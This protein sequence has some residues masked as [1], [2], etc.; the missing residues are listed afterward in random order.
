MPISVLL[1]DGDSD[2]AQSVVHALVDPWL[3]WTV[4]MA[5]TL[6]QARR[7]LAR[8]QIDVVLTVRSMA[9]G[10]A[11]DV[12]KM[13]DDVPALIMVLPGEEAQAAQ[14]MRHGFS[15]FLVQT[16]QRDHLLALPAQIEAVL[17]RSTVARARQTAEAM[18]ARQHRLLQAIS[19]VQ[20]IFI[21]QTSPRAAFD[22][23]LQEL[24]ALTGSAFGLVGQVQRAPQGLPFLRVHAMTDISW[25]AASRVR[26]AQH[27]QEGM[28]FDNPHSLLGAALL[29]GEAVISN[30]PAADPRSAGRPQ[31][32]PALTTYLG[33]PIHAAGELVAMVGL[34]NRPGGYSQADVQ[35]LQP[36]RNT[37]GQL[38]LARRAE[39]ARSEV[40][41]RLARTSALLSEKTRALEG[42]LASVSQGIANVDAN[43]RIRLYN[44]RYLE[45]LDLPEELLATQPLVE[46]VVRFQTE[47]GDFGQDLDLIESP[48]RAYLASDHAGGSA[49]PETY[50]RKTRA[51]RYLEVRTRLLEA[52]GW[53]RSFADVTDYLGTLQALRESEARWRSLT[54]LSS[55]WYWEQDA[56]F[57]FVRFDGS[58]ER[59]IPDETQYGLTR[60]E[61]PD[62]VVAPGQWSKHRQQL[63]AH[64]VFHDF[65][66]QRTTTDGTPVWVSISGE[67]IF[68]AE[69]RCTGYRGVARNI[70]ERKKAEAEIQRLVFYDE[71]TALPN[72]RLLLDRLEHATL[73]CVREAC[74]GALLFLDLDNFKAINDTLGHEMGDR[75][76]VQVAARL[77]S[78]VRAMD[79]VARL[80]GDEFVV[81]LQQ[82]H[83]AEPE[84]AVEAEAIAQKII[85]SLNGPFQ[86]DNREIH[87]TPS[88]G[89][90]LFRDAGQPVHELLQ[91]ADLA[92]YQAK[93]QGRNTLCFFDPAMQAAASARSALE[94]DIRQGLQRDEFLL[95]YQPVVNE[96]G[97]VL[98]AE[99]LVR[100]K[101]PQRGMVPPGDF[102]PLAEQTGLI[103]PLGRQVMRLACAQLALWAAMP[104]SAGWS[105]AVNVSAQEFRHPHF[106]QQV[107]DA[108]RESGA[109]PRRLK[110]EL[111]ESLMLHDV[112]DSILKMQALRT[113]GV[114]FSL[115]DFGTGYSSLGY[116]KRLPL[117]QLKIDQSFVRDVLTDPNDA[118]IACTIITLASSLGLD[119]VAEGVETEGQRAFL[120]RNGCRQF[121]GYLFGRPGPVDLLSKI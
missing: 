83:S 119:V 6:A 62:A 100:W 110:L 22:A 54:D 106:V 51:G 87:S 13:L 113:L 38:E 56:D 24:M 96:T 73:G 53:V 47:R 41:S 55:D 102:I 4:D 61:L 3:D 69:G 94:G 90:A 18:L 89:I 10:T 121:Q 45:L 120:L 79:T 58:V 108:L 43:G 117:D 116:L 80:G 34:A 26:Y 64:E 50:I 78:C 57:R 107:L 66:M 42:T 85:A 12:L 14:A 48:A 15:D 76:L 30:N 59:G 68:D 19:K 88:I 28:V 67:P 105:V 72:R 84:A 104:H 93:A 33:L 82:L 74:H 35:F 92:M 21:A 81:I 52:G 114:G 27:A 49:M 16:P 63:Q 9:D 97:D 86:V 77:R 101:H 98:G 44:R 65:E 71:L 112:E 91:R 36:L 46:D 39:L 1:I 60:W 7:I 17:E 109:S 32:H 70:T 111:T 11:F 40:E 115:D 103:L 25:D 75:L 31:G 99:A 118:A 29:T 23:V 8:Q 2:H 20:A 37:V 95:H 5:P